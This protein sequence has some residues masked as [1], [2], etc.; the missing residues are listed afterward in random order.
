[1]LLLNF[2]NKYLTKKKTT[3]TSPSIQILK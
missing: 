3:K 1:M 2:V